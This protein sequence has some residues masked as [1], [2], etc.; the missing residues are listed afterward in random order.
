MKDGSS[1]S[2]NF[3]NGEITGKGL[4]VWECGMQYEGDWIQGEREG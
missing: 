2:G 1:Y 3:V 4:R